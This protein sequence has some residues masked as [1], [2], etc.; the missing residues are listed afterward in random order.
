LEFDQDE[1]YT[2]KHSIK[3][4]LPSTCDEIC[5][6]QLV[7]VVFGV[8]KVYLNDSEQNPPLAL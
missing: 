7:E 3:H 6:Q 2:N 4:A 8:L 5:S 1:V